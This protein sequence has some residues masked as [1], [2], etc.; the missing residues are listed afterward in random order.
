[1]SI[2]IKMVKS[3]MSRKII[4]LI[5][6]ISTYWFKKSIQRSGSDNNPRP[7]DSARGCLSMSFE[8]CD[9]YRQS[10][11]TPTGGP[12][13]IGR[14]VEKTKMLRTLFACLLIISF[15]ETVCAI[16]KLG[17]AGIGIAEFV[18]PGIAS[19]IF[20]GEWDNAVILGLPHYAALAKANEA[21]E[22]EYYQEDSNFPVRVVLTD[23]EIESA[24]YDDQYIWSQ[25]SKDRALYSRFSVGFRWAA[26]YDVY[27]SG[28]KKDVETDTYS[29][30]FS[31]LRI[32]KFYDNWMFWA[33][34]ALQAYIFSLD[35]KE[36]RE[37]WGDFLWEEEKT[38][39][40]LLMLTRGLTRDEVTR[41][42]AISNFSSSVGEEMFFRGVV[43][44]YFFNGMKSSGFNPS[45]SRHLSI[46]LSSS[47]SA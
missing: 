29:L 5:S 21:K 42:V 32:D 41:D 25:E 20:L 14:C 1:M 19:S 43:Q 6:A 39:K 27:S 34:L 3:P 9:K 13:N 7:I 12:L 44:D 22:S 16:S 28:C 47:L 23:Q 26:V 15:S 17:C 45:L 46:L 36:R 37:T 4:M 33:P 40:K 18:L 8:L 31:A 38:D 2:S 24:E 11:Q 35:P 10:A 30:M